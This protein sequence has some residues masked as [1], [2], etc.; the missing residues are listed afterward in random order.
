M[1]ID[2]PARIARKDDKVI[3]EFIGRVRSRTDSLS[4]ARMVA[5]PKW[6][7]AQSA[8]DFDEVVIVTSGILTVETEG[9]VHSVLPGTVAFA[10]RGE[11]VTYRNDQLVPCEYWSICVPAFR[12]ER[13]PSTR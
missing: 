5:P 4:V 9:D 11:E 1:H 6:K 7:E 13:E 10:R 3:D 12:P 2:K 8:P